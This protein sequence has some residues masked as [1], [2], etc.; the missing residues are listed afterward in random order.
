[1]IPPRDAVE[2]FIARNALPASVERAREYG[3]ELVESGTVRPD[4][5]AADRT[6]RH[7]SRQWCLMMPR[8]WQ[9]HVPARITGAASA[10]T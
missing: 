5:F 10:S 9:L 3:A 1:M 2:A 8:R 7:T 4:F 6:E